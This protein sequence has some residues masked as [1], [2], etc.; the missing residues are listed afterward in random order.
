MYIFDIKNHFSNFYHKSIKY[1]YIA[2][3][4]INYIIFLDNS[5]LF[6]Y[7]RFDLER[8]FDEDLR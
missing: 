7:E 1:A 8:S 3:V 4:N 6:I 2:A 5:D